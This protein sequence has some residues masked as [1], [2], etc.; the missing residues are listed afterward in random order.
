MNEC[1][2]NYRGGIAFEA[3]ARQHSLTIDLAQEKGG[4]DS[5]MNPPEIFMASL[6]SC[7]GVYVVRY[8]KNAKIDAEGLSIDLEWQ[9]SDDKT[10]ISEIKA[11]I[12]LPKAEVGKR[13]K[14]ILEV[15]HHCLIHNTIL[16]QPQIHMTLQGK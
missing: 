14:A 1:K 16:C 8:C 7:I 4:E 10:K 5:G 6:G 12:A 9:L 13:D 11:R 3:K 2:V 15:A